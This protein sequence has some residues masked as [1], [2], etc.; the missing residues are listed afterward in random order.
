[1]ARSAL[2]DVSEAIYGALNVSTM[3]NLATSGV[4]SHVPQDTAPPYVWYTVDERD[5]DGT[6]GAVMKDCVVRVHAFSTYQ[7]DQEAQQIINAAVALLRGTTPALDNHTPLLL[8]HDGSTPATDED[9][10]GVQ[11]KHIVADFRF[12]VLED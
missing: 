12:T 2:E 8:V 6:F 4:F 3:T 11:T 9:V 5:V 1:M 7:G 10:G